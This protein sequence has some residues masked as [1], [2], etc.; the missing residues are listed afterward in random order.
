M[1]IRYYK[2]SNVYFS[3]YEIN[4]VVLEGLADN[5]FSSIK[6]LITWITQDEEIYGIIKD[7][8]QRVL[9]TMYRYK[10][11]ESNMHILDY[12]DIAVFEFDNTLSIKTILLGFRKTIDESISHAIYYVDNNILVYGDDQIDATEYFKSQ[13]K[14]RELSDFILNNNLSDIFKY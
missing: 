5:V 8:N 14:D 7:S 6:E 9:V 1:K 2:N 12:T 3:I 11:D 10:Q 13:C 4:G